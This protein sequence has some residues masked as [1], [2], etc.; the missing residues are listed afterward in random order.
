MLQRMCKALVVAAVFCVALSDSQVQA[1]LQDNCY[2]VTVRNYTQRAR[3]FDGF[4][5]TRNGN[6]LVFTTWSGLEGSWVINGSTRLRGPI[7]NFIAVGSHN[8]TT[9]RLTGIEYIRN[10][11]S[12]IEGVWRDNKGGAGS[13]SGFVDVK[14]V[15]AGN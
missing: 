5:F 11:Q 13:F 3:G 4:C 2:Q 12:V 9:L 14:G 8:G 15:P 10:G 6:K 7:Y 1:A